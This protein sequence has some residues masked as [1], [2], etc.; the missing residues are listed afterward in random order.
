M[1]FA[2]SGKAKI[3][4]QLY[5][6]A[7]LSR[8]LKVPPKRLRALMAA[9]EMPTADVIIPGGGHKGLRWS[10][11]RVRLIQAKWA[12]DPAMWRSAA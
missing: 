10:A 4:D 1:S 3:A 12:T 5:T 9:K 7:D 6:L 2:P 8:L 11:T